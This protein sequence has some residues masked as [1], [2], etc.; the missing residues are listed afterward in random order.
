M[1]EAFS[2]M[3]EKRTQ[4]VVNTSYR[5]PWRRSSWGGGSSMVRGGATGLAERSLSSGGII[6]SLYI[7]DP[8]CK[9]LN[10]SPC[11]RTDILFK[12][13]HNMHCNPC[14]QPQT[15]A[16][17]GV[18]RMCSGTSQTSHEQQARHCSVG[19]VKAIPLEGL[20][21]RC[22]LGFHREPRTSACSWWRSG[23]SNCSCFT[24]RYRYLEVA[25]AG[26]G[27]PFA[28]MKT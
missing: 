25:P 17:C 2:V 3:K 10:G 6:P 5:L 18:W 8:R 23:D 4:E 15:A 13:V 24:A 12:P 16:V 26:P 14:C 21:P 28:V 19:L 11:Q 22:T 27:L 7:L 9:R 1:G 20:G